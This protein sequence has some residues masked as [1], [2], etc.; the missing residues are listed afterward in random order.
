MTVAPDAI[1]RLN[2]YLADQLRSLAGNDIPQSVYHYTSSQSMRAIISSGML[3][4]HNLAQMNDFA[5]GRYAA[6]FMRA[7]IDRG[8]AIQPDQDAMALLGAMRQQL[9][10]VDLANVFALSFTS[11][12]DEPGM[13]RLYADRGRGFSFAIPTRNALSWG[14][15]GHKGMFASCI[16]KS[17]RLTRFCADA[18]AKIQ[19]IYLRDAGN[20]LAVDPAEYA[21]MF[22]DNISWF[23]PVFK[24]DVWA[25]EKEWRFIFARPQPEHKSSDG[26]HYIELPLAL[27]TTQNPQPITAICAGPDCDYEDDILPL[28]QVLYERGFGGLGGNFPIYTSTKH[29]TRPGRKPPNK[30]EAAPTAEPSQAT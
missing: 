30:R 17:G 19:E 5:E 6:S 11:D 24:P 13:W 12:G 27:P 4:A 2:E 10:R 25:D 16:Y 9:T 26:R 22:L 20:G 18:L 29:V 14:G 28:Q 3:R 21:A 1:A 7:H 23:A 15:D 8:S